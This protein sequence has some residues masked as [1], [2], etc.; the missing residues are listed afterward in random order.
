MSR[1]DI[2]VELGELAEHVLRACAPLGGEQFTDLRQ[3]AERAGE[4]ARE[5]LRGLTGS[6][7]RAQAELAQAGK[8]WEQERSAR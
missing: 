3:H 4:T 6:Q 5:A 7:A 8:E 2:A 1:R